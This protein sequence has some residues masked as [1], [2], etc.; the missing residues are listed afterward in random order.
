MH[1]LVFRYDMSDGKRP[2]RVLCLT[3]ACDRP[4]SELFIGMHRAGHQVDVMCNPSGRFFEYL[5]EAGLKVLPMKLSGRF[6]REGTDKIREQLHASDYDILHAYNPRALACGLRAS[7]GLP[8]RVVAYRGVS[9]NISYLNPESWLTFLHPR[10][11]RIVAVCDAVRDY[12]AGVH[13]LGWRLPPEKLT[14]IYKGHDLSWYQQAPADL[15]GFGIPDDAFV[16]C[17]TGRDRPR[18]G[19]DILLKAAAFCPT[20]LNIHFLLVGDMDGNEGLRQLARDSGHES[21]I[22]FAGYQQNAPQLAAASDAFTLPSVEREGL[23][24]AVIEAM[25]Y[26]TPPVVSDVGGMPELVVDGD[27]GYVVSRGDAESLAEA[28]CKLARNQEGARLMGE[29][30]RERIRERFHTTQ[31]VAAT[32][33]MYRELLSAYE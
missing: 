5:R 20:E 13:F 3:D 2:L 32:L 17:A 24:R 21:R 18:K 33:A 22:H 7:K 10:V 15:S 31:T 12:L 26:G 8:V 29:R 30:A 14:R 25:A 16:V 19:Y 6:D 1:G 23:P 28:I 11:D 9:G 4:E 27:C